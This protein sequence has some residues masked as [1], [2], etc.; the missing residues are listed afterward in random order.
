MISKYSSRLVSYEES[1][2]RYVVSK[3]PWSN[4]SDVTIATP[5]APQAPR[6]ASKNRDTSL[7]V[8]LVAEVMQVRILMALHLN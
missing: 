6:V 7:A 4:E 8:F 2:L 1:S 3:E 5:I